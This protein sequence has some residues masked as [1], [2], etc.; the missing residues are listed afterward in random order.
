MEKL[1]LLNLFQEWEE[2]DIKEN[3]EEGEFK[4]DLLRTSINASMYPHQAQTINK[5]EVFGYI[6]LRKQITII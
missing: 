4:Y 3:D 1:Y 6:I 5:K 2:G